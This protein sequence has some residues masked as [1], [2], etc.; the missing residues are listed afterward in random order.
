MYHNA[1]IKAYNDQL[2]ELFGLAMKYKCIVEKKSDYSMSNLFECVYTKPFQVEP[3]VARYNMQLQEQRPNL[4]EIKRCINDLKALLEQGLDKEGARDIFASSSQDVALDNFI[5][6]PELVK[7]IREEVNK[8]TAI[9]AQIAVLDSVLSGFQDEE[10]LLDQF[11]EAMYTGTIVKRGAVYVYD[12]NEEED[13]WEPFVNLTKVNKYVEF[14]I[15][16]HFRKLDAKRKAMI[17]RKSERRNQD[18]VASEE[19]VAELIRKLDEMGVS[20]TEAKSDLE[21]TRDELINGEEVYGF[22]RKAAA[23]VSELSRNLK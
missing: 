4:G 22:Y 16:D 23:K 12:R 20:M 19:K 10:K 17:A 3:F 1:R 21:F 8:Y 7:R 5:R 14:T 11:V 6:S 18:M 15:F 9:E 13:D 2:R